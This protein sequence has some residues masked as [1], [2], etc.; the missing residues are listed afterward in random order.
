MLRTS[1]RVRHQ[2][3]GFT[4]IEAVFSMFLTVLFLGLTVPA[5]LHLLDYARLTESTE[6]LIGSL[7]WAQAEAD[8][9]NQ[10]AALRLAPYGNTYEID[11]AAGQL[12]TG[13]FQTG[14]EYTDGYLQL[15][16]R[17]IT[18]DTHGNASVG[19]TI[20]LTDGYEEQ[21]IQMYI[22]SGLQVPGGDIP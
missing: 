16:S 3:D 20:R 7:R 21:D 10:W 19:G 11:N 1:W 6:R 5:G 13:V 8:A 4:L 17:S 12:N 18:Y 2:T 15:P 9:S 22:N 14:I